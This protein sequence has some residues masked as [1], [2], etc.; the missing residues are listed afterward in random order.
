VNVTTARLQ[1]AQKEWQRGGTAPATINRRM[2]SLKRAYSLALKGGKINRAP[3]FPAKLPELNARQG[4][5]EKAEFLA[6]A[7]QLEPD[8]R[9]LAEWCFVTGMRK[10]EATKLTWA[11]F[12]RETWTLRLHARDAK[13]RV[14][15]VIPLGGALRAIIERRLASRRLDCQLIFNREGEPIRDIRKSWANA[16]KAAGLTGRLFHD[17]R[18]TGVRNLVRAGVS[19]TVAMAISGHRTASVFRRYD[20]TSEADIAAAVERVSTYLDQLPEKQTVV[21]LAAS[22]GRRG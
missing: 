20:I 13:T 4:F 8:L 12:D 10:G 15:R 18:R 21:P 19:Q 5:F 7:A 9:D 14:G 3:T 11:G 1:E 16:C 22:G 6:V 2:T 17:F